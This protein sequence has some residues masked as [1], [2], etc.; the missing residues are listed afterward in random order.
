MALSFEKYNGDGTTRNFGVPFRYISRDHVVVS[1]D[2]VS[3]PVT[4][5]NDALVQLA[6]AP[7]PGTVVEVRR[8][9][10]SEQRLVDFSDGSTLTEENLDLSADQLLFIAQEAVDAVQGALVS[11]VFGS[12]ALQNSS[13]V[14]ITGGTIGTGVSIPALTAKA[15][16]SAVNTALAAKADVSAVNAALDT[17][18]PLA[19]PAFTGT[20]TFG[21][22]P[23]FNGQTPWD[24]GNMQGVIQSEAEAGTGTT[25]RAWTAQRVR[26]AVAAYAAP[27]NDS[28]LTDER[29]PTNS[30]VTDAKVALDA[31]V[32]NRISL[33]KL[34]F[35]QGGTGSVNRSAQAKARDLVDAADFGAVYDGTTNDGSAIQAA[36][37]HLVALRGGGAV[38]ITGRAR[39]TTLVTVPQGC[40]I[41]ADRA[42]PIGGIRYDNTCWWLQSPGALILSRTTTIRI[43]NGAFLDGLLIHAPELTT[44]QTGAQ[45]AAWTGTAVTLQA[46]ASDFGVRGCTIL[47]YEFGVAYGNGTAG[48]SRANLERVLID[49]R[50]GVD[51]LG[52]FDVP[53][54]RDVHCY[55]FTSY[56]LNGDTGSIPQS[57]LVRNGTAFRIR[58]TGALAN[59]WAQVHGCFSYGFLWGFDTDGGDD[60][61][62]VNCGVDYPPSLGDANNAIGFRFFGDAQNPK[63]IGCQVAAVKWA[64]Y[65]EGSLSDSTL[66][67]IASSFWGVTVGVLSNGRKVSISGGTSF[68]GFRASLGIGVEVINTGTGPV[69]VHGCH[70]DGVHTAFKQPVGSNQI[71]QKNN[72]FNGITFHH[73]NGNISGVSPNAGGAVTIDPFDDVVQVF[74]NG[75]NQL[76]FIEPV[77]ACVGK[78]LTLVFRG[79]VT[80]NHNGSGNG[81]LIIGAGFNAANNTVLQVVS[82][83]V[84]W[85]GVSGPRTN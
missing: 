6:V 83:G 21:A 82:D 37:D 80:V 48:I 31:T 69:Y 63:L 13:N 49:C 40:S 22:R 12:M 67:I 65:D 77:A 50:N 85:Y 16:V 18:A 52:D 76:S 58:A 41:V 23:T 4:W 75:T 34:R 5:L 20:A 38:R 43:N 7:A 78:T 51:I 70:F 1:V 14:T 29:V 28:R 73:L 57:D 60:V 9:T 44:R 71:R 59:D 53:R 45:A 55:P 79:A 8:I 3:F 26:Q 62:F 36:L 10:P 72:T 56:P 39:V 74:T 64:V 42:G 2:A 68:R 15:D 27:L 35:N 33:D 66:R 11:P 61:T 24:N 17:K 46:G 19:S 47:G 32:A 25:N 54:L 84:N 81:R 30:S